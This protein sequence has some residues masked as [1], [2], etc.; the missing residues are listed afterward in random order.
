MLYIGYTHS[1][2][3]TTY[4]SL[5]LSGNKT[6]KYHATYTNGHV[7]NSVNHVGQLIVSVMSGFSN[8]RPTSL[9]MYEKMQYVFIFVVNQSIKIPFSFSSAFCGYT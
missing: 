6:T 9:P 8:D 5:H 4:L 3:L 7:E 1:I 2:A